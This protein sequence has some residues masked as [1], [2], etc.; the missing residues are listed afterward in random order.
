MNTA[1]ISKN[2]IKNLLGIDFI[3]L[4]KLMGVF[5]LTLALSFSTG[6]KDVL[7]NVSLKTIMIPVYADDG[8]DNASGDGGSN[9]IPTASI[10]ASHSS[11]IYPTMIQ[12][13]LSSSNASSCVVTDNNG[14]TYVNLSE[15]ITSKTLSAET[16]PGTLSLTAT[17]YSGL[18][19]SG[20]A[21]SPSNMSVTVSCPAGQS[22]D[23]TICTVTSGGGDKVSI[24]A[25]TVVMDDVIRMAEGS[26]EDV[27]E[28]GLIPLAAESAT[29][30][31]RPAP[32]SRGIGRTGP[33]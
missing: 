25:E 6:N 24:K 28:S 7:N 27:K 21:S 4:W 9:I 33:Q 14:I 8:G 20:Q 31:S 11:A 15:N 18:D 10:S 5:M 16:T 12:Y 17:C 32:T 30:V 26:S 3:A 19:G 22:W 13:S 2:T 29:T 23:G 1:T